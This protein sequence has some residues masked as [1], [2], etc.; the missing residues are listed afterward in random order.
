[1]AT[2]NTTDNGQATGVEVDLTAI[3]ATKQF[4]E[5]SDI[6]VKAV[7]AKDK[8]ADNYAGLIASIPDIA[9]FLEDYNGTVAFTKYCLD[10]RGVNSKGADRRKANRI[11]YVKTQSAIALADLLG[12]APPENK[13]DNWQ[14][15]AYLEKIEQTLTAHKLTLQDLAVAI[16]DKL[17]TVDQAAE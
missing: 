17:A 3:Q 8:F 11:A 14:L 5:A 10:K 2:E 13:S 15:A 16:D 4:V 12:F 7:N 1:M 9:E 6:L